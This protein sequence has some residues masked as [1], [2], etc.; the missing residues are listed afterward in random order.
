MEKKVKFISVNYGCD[1]YG[2]HYFMDD[3]NNCYYWGSYSE[4]IYDLL[5]SNQLKANDDLIVSF[6]ETTR[7]FKFASHN[8]QVV[9]N[10]RIKKIVK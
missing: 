7:T 4:K 10:L 9:K 6:K 8:W 3:N 2:N 1:D 5:M